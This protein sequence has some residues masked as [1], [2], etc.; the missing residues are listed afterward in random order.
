[1]HSGNPPLG[2]G[3]VD[4]QQEAQD[5]HVF[6]VDVP[7]QLGELRTLFQQ[8][9]QPNRHGAAQPAGQIANV[10]VALNG[11][12]GPLQQYLRLANRM[13]SRLTKLENNQTLSNQDLYELVQ[14]A[15]NATL[16]F[17]TLK[18]EIR[19]LIRLLEENYSALVEGYKSD[20][21]KCATTG[22]I[23]VC[24]FAAVAIFWWWNPAGWVAV[25]AYGLGG[26]AGGVG[27][28]VAG[29]GAHKVWDI[30]RGKAFGKKDRVREFDITMKELDRCANQARKAIVT[31]FCAQVMQKRL[32]DT[33]PEHDR[34][35]LL[36]TLGVDVDAVSSSVYNQELICDR[37]RRFRENNSNLRTR[38]ERVQ[39]DVNF[40]L[41]TTEQ[42]TEALGCENLHVALDYWLG[43]SGY[44]MIQG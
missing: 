29:A 40:E 44:L 43:A 3:R 20:R 38:M 19:P 8:L 31:V 11:A 7:Q 41:Q 12:A 30:E 6:N 32:D 36:A 25:G 14:D 34:R 21:T 10:Q 16:H 1:M 23:R 35:T 28:G 42:A 24:V 39:T 26:A 4:I 2:N 5:D 17:S 15:H 9:R 18:Q 13:E 33:L 22:A 37:L 27:G